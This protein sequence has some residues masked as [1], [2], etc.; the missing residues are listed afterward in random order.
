MP[1]RLVVLLRYRRFRHRDEPEAVAEVLRV[2][3]EDLAQSPLYAVARYRLPDAAAAYYAEPPPLAGDG[4]AVNDESLA[5]RG[6]ALAYSA[7]EIAPE[8]HARG[9]GQTETQPAAHIDAKP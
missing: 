3:P 9:A 2:R 1:Q 5:R 6:A 8:P 4:E 7:R